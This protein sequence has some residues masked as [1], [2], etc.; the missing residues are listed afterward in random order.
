MGRRGPEPQ[1]ETG[2]FFTDVFAGQEEEGG[3]G[4]MGYLQDRAGQKLDEEPFIQEC[5]R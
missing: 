5:R 3:Q 2:S 1:G 4:R